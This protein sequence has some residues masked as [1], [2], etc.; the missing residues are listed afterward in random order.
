LENIKEASYKRAI[1]FITNWYFKLL[2]L[3]ILTG[4]FLTSYL[5]YP[6]TE[7]VSYQLDD[8]GTVCQ[9]KSEGIGP[10]C[11][12]D[13]YLPMNL[14]NLDSPW[15]N[16]NVPYPPLGLA[17][18]K[19]FAYLH[20]AFPGHLSLVTYLLFALSV[21][22]ASVLYISRKLNLS[23][24]TSSLI[25]LFAIL[26]APVITILDRGNNTFLVLPALS[27]MA[28]NLEEEK[29]KNFIISGILIVLIKPQFVLLGL[30]FLIL[31]EWRNLFT[32]LSATCIGISIS[33][34]LYPINIV[35]NLLHW[36]YHLLLFQQYTAFGEKY[37]VNLS[38]NNL[39]EIYL[40]FFGVEIRRVLISVTVI[41]L[42]IISIWALRR[43]A[44]LRSQY[45]IFTLVMI[46]PV[47]FV[48]TAFH[49]Y[50]FVLLIPMALLISQAFGEVPIKKYNISNL[51]SS[52]TRASLTLATM[53][54]C[55]LPWSLSSGL[56][57]TTESDQGRNISL[58]WE[59]AR[60][61]LAVTFTFLVFVPIKLGNEA[62]D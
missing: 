33:F 9:P 46:I 40:N 2:A 10:H 29:R 11:F 39:I 3:S 20:E 45:E 42:L 62:I 53:A 1:N 13:F 41:S 43:S 47:L 54:S 5:K 4:I 12:S 7:G 27:Y 25:F 18:F 17:I 21:M 24:R 6:F 59:I 50:L 22:A 32:W 52:K 26:S 44:H 48:G 34:L 36:A 8:A 55:L 15:S 31:R 14:S 37:P 51:I 56:L 30:F 23:S 49:Y 35:S 57:M 28:L 38:F 58:T 61:A 60:I 19:P 16:S